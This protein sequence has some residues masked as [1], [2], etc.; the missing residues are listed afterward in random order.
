MGG[1][2]PW[3]AERYLPSEL[4]GLLLSLLDRLGIE[5]RCR[6]SGCRTAPRSA[7]TSRRSRPSGCRRSS[8]S[9]A[10]TSTPPTCRGSRP[11]HELKHRVRAAGALAVRVPVPQARRGAEQGQRRLPR[12]D[13][14]AGG[15]LDRRAAAAPRRCGASAAPLHLRRRGPRAGRRAGLGDLAVARRSAGC[16]CCCSAPTSRSPYEKCRSGHVSGSLRRSRRPR[17]GSC[18]AYGRTWSPGWGRRWCRWS[19][20][21]CAPFCEP[22][23]ALVLC[24]PRARAVSAA[25]RPVPSSNKGFLW[26]TSSRRSSATSRTRLPASATR[27]S[28]PS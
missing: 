1:S 10:A 18:P 15:V 19:G 27:R 8:C 23:P 25:V 6:S 9:T 7:A 13:P 4:A 14:R 16:R 17:Y 24:S 21:G 3:P 28:S 11:G 12:L 22:R 2:P 20:T 26:P 5:R